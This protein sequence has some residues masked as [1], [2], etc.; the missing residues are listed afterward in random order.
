[1]QQMIRCSSNG[2]AYHMP[3]HMMPV[4]AY[5]VEAR[6]AHKA[7]FEAAIPALDTIPSLPRK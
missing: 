3:L 2:Y 5:P 6:L 7:A 1:M 4:S